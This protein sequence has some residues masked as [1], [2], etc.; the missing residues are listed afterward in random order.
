MY[1][2]MYKYST[3]AR[4]AYLTA[5]R[6]SSPHAHHHYDD[7]AVGREREGGEPSH[8][9]PGERVPCAHWSPSSCLVEPMAPMR[10]DG[11]LLVSTLKFRE[12]VMARKGM[13]AARRAEMDPGG[14]AESDSLAA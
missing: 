11:Q 1:L 8:L 10:W 2:D 14:R 3:V 4:Y 7:R 13:A 9:H 5:Q 12:Q 6:V